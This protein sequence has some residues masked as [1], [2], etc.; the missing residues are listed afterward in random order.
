MC[1]ESSATYG[2]AGLVCVL[3]LS[4]VQEKQC[5]RFGHL[6]ADQGDIHGGVLNLRRR[7]AIFGS[8]HAHRYERG[9]PMLGELRNLPTD[10]LL[11]I[12]LVILA[13]GQPLSLSEVAELEQIQHE[14][15]RRGELEGKT[16]MN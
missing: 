9:I 3:P 6:S 15:Q 14:L 7:L 10:T 8:M 4:Q 5:P 16:V 2:C 1:L 11:D 12:V 13:A